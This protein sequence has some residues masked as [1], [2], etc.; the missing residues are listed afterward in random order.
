MDALAIGSFEAGGM[1]NY[2]I[3]VVEHPVAGLDPNIVK[4][5]IKPAAFDQVVKALTERPRQPA[6]KPKSAGTQ[7]L[8]YQGQDLIEATRAMGEDFLA[9]N[10]GDG[11][12]LVPP[13]PGRVREMLKATKMAP[14]DVLGILGPRNGKVTVENLAINAVMAGARPEYMPALISM[15]Q[16][17]LLP[18]F[19]LAQINVTTN[20]VVPMVILSGPMTDVSE[21]NVNAGTGVFGPGWQANATIGR[22]LDLLTL[23]T[24]GAT[25]GPTAK[26]THKQ[27]AKYGAAWAV[28]RTNNPFPS[29]QEQLLTTRRRI[30][31]ITQAY[32]ELS[33]GVPKFEPVGKNDNVVI[34]FGL[35][36]RNNVNDN[37]CLNGECLLNSIATSMLVGETARGAAGGIDGQ[38]LIALGPQH[39]KILA[40]DGWTIDKMREFLFKEARYP[41]KRWV[42]S[43][44]ETVESATK[45]WASR[46]AA[47]PFGKDGMV[48]MV[49]H[50]E[51]IF[52]TVAGGPGSHS[53]VFIGAY[54]TTVMQK[55][56]K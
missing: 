45:V 18:E 21:L 49:M 41:L 47:E 9:R 39:A 28:D 14:T 53:A 2:P 50:P 20:P 26:G 34:M 16:A 38:Y 23:T 55:V 35:L 3:V 17:S 52:F 37:N 15:V 48:A 24:G 30:D 4:A 36:D 27:F 6:A 5:R 56:V 1:P 54:G 8:V 13:T 51:D 31:Q 46:K 43:H 44:S 7:R 25:P 33:L 40:N 19:N 32:K 12:P 10:W 29:L 11:L 22:T 42:P